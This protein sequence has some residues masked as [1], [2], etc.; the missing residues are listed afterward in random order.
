MKLRLTSL[1]IALLLLSNDF[2]LG[3]SDEKEERKVFYTRE[4]G[5]ELSDDDLNIT[6][7]YNEKE[8]QK[9]VLEGNFEK[10][11]KVINKDNVNTKNTKTGKTLLRKH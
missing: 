6:R 9:L 10:V 5:N 11:K 3:G 1:S 4:F 2:V 7:E 8:L